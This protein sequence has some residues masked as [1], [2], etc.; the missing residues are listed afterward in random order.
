VKNELV[1]TA[2]N[3]R[4]SNAN[5]WKDFEKRLGVAAR[6][7]IVLLTVVLLGGLYLAAT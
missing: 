5:N 3:L 2:E 6:A 4:V 1:A 7:A